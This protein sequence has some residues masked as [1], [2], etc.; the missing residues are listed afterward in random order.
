MTQSEMRQEVTIDTTKILRIIQEY[1]ERLYATK[2]DN[3]EEM[4]K[5]LEIHN[6]SRLNHEKLENPTRP[7]TGKEIETVI[8]NLKNKSPEPDGFTDEV[9][10]SFKDLTPKAFPNIEE[11][12]RPNLLYKSNITDTK[13]RQ[14]QHEKRLQAV[15]W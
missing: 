4:D 14:G 3:L 11:G 5:V 2:F 8:K 10:Q 7:I 6:L 15:I 1:C 13:T 12:I 9:Y